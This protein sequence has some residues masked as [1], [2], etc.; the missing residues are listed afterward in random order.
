MRPIV[1]D[2]NPGSGAVQVDWMRLA[3]YATAGT[4]TSRVLNAGASIAWN[5][6]AWTAQVPAGSDPDDERPIRQ[7]AGSGC[8][9]DVVHDAA[10]QRRIAGNHVAVRPV[11]RRDERQRRRDAGGA[12]RLVRAARAAADHHRRGRERDR[13]HGRHDQRRLRADRSPD[14]RCRRSA[15]RIRPANGTA[16]GG[17]YT[18]S[19]RNGGVRARQRRRSTVNVPWPATRRSKPTKPSSSIW[20]RRRMRPSAGRRASARSSTTISRRCR[21]AASSVTEGNTGSVT[22]TFTVDLDGGVHASR[23]P[24]PTRRRTA[25]AT[26]GSDY[27]AAAGTVTFAAG[28]T[29]QTI[30]VPVLGDAARRGQR[31]VYSSL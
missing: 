16:S 13:G 26:A 17:D 15:C 10:S 27:T 14:P 18:A 30:A 11:P 24:S 7:H 12:G 21:S 5:S 28:T 8:E 1:S 25:T 4:F 29:T 22:A 9:L 31:D 6:A 23:S 2:F 3:P 20:A 19:L